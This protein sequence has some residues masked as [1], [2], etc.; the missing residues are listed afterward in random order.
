MNAR[1]LHLAGLILQAVT[2]PSLTLWFR[3]DLDFNPWIIAGALGTLGCV[4]ALAGALAGR[5]FIPLGS[6]GTVGALVAGVGWVSWLVVGFT[7]QPDDPVI[8]ITG[9]LAPP[10]LALG[11][12]AHLLSYRRRADSS[13]S[14]GSRPRVATTGAL[15]FGLALLAVEVALYGI[16]MTETFDFSTLPLILVQIIL[17]GWLVGRA[18]LTPAQDAGVSRIL[19]LVGGYLAIIGAVPFFLLGQLSIVVILVAGVLELRE[20]KRSGHS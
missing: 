9:L 16:L 15:W 11:I 18:H 1:H 10:G 5:R 2:Y 3:L 13:G 12:I 17:G 14:P 6:L 8:N 20:R 4:L 7:S 19:A